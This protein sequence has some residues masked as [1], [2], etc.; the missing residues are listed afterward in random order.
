MIG[1]A[2]AQADV[3]VI[4]LGSR[5]LDAS[6]V[7][8]E[9]T[10]LEINTLGDPV[11]RCLPRGTRFIF[12][13]A[14]HAAIGR[15]RVRR[16][17]RKPAADLRLEGRGRPAD[18]GRGTALWRIH[19]WIFAGFLCAGLRR[20]GPAW[21]R[22]SGQSSAG[23]RPRLLYRLHT[24][25]EFITADLGPPRHGHGRRSCYDGLVETIGGSAMPGVGWAAGIE[26]PSP[27]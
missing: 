4:A 11:P 22:F 23:P 21:Y 18:H 5:I 16:L 20:F 26:R 10:I 25:F 7:A 12:F 9:R 15:E 3:E 24:A 19:E 2:Q 14:C 1:V 8:G 27:C 17:E 6:A 13:G